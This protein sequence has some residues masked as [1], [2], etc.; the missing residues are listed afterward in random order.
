MK[1]A[2]IYSVILIIFLGT[3]QSFAQDNTLPQLFQQ[4]KSAIT[5]KDYKTAQSILST[6]VA[7]Y[8]G[9]VKG[10]YNLGNVHRDLNQA[11]DA[12]NAYSKALELDPG[13]DNARFNMA[14]V[15]AARGTKVMNIP[16]AIRQFDILWAKNTTDFDVNMQ[17]VDLHYRRLEYPQMEKHI[18]ILNDNHSNR[19][20]TKY[21]SG[22]LA[23]RQSRFKEAQSAFEAG[24]AINPASD[25]LKGKV[26]EYLFYENTHLSSSNDT[27]NVYE[28]YKRILELQPSNTKAMYELGAYAWKIGDKETAIQVYSDYTVWRHSYWGVYANLAE[29]LSYD[30]TRWEEAFQLTDKALRYGPFRWEPRDT[31]G[32][33]YTQK[34]ELGNAEKEFYT[35][36]T[37]LNL[38]WSDIVK[39][40]KKKAWSTLSKYEPHVQYH[41]LA[42]LA[43]KKDIK[44]VWLADKFVSSAKDARIRDR[45]QHLISANKHL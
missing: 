41:L 40:N 26:V 25:D 23:E 21:F 27:A 31:R 39:T 19:W 16:E 3:I 5:I 12:V 33:I 8:P 1:K 9:D 28:N 14:R 34:G 43:L 11:D 44:W 45:V 38:N 13:Y 18:V 17:L 15:Y 10:W 32:W 7:K 24:L 2:F 20:E 37:M 36:S 22:L 30:S 4:A 42:Y 29:I 35:M 6:L